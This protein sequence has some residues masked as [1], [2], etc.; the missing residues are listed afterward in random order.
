VAP[1]NFYHVPHV[2]GAR[3]ANTNA[4]SKEEVGRQPDV[5]FNGH[6]LELL[7]L[8]GVH[9][10]GFCS[11]GLRSGEG[12]S[13]VVIETRTGSIIL[14]CHAELRKG[15]QGAKLRDDGVG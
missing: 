9:E 7:Q 14:E 8:S 2:G 6:V 3:F 1:I 11:S 13:R 5:R 12:A 4:G 10:H 15:A